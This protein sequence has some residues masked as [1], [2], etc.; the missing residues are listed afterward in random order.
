MNGVAGGMLASQGRSRR[1][2]GGN[3][4]ESAV[5]YPTSMVAFAVAL[6]MLAV[7]APDLAAQPPEK[8]TRAK[9]MGPLECRVV[10]PG[11]FEREGVVRSPATVQ[12][13]GRPDCGGTCQIR[14]A[15]V[16]GD[17]VFDVAEEVFLP[18]QV[19]VIGTGIV[20]RNHDDL[21]RYLR[22]LANWA[23]GVWTESG[24]DAELRF[25]G[26]ARHPKLTGV[27]LTRGASTR[28]GYVP[29]Q[30]V[31]ERFDAHLVY[32]I[33]PHHN[34]NA[35][36]GSGVLGV[37]SP[38]D[39]WRPSDPYV[40]HVGTSND[41]VLS[42]DGLRHGL[43]HEI[44]HN[45]GIHHDP[46]TRARGGEGRPVW[47]GGQGFAGGGENNK[48][49]CG[50]GQ[51]YSR[52]E[53]C[54]GIATHMAYASLDNPSPIWRFSTS[55]SVLVVGEDDSACIDPGVQCFLEYGATYP[56]GEKGVHE[57][58]EVL[59]WNIPRLAM[60][61]ELADDPDPEPD[62]PP[63]DPNPETDL[64]LHGGRFTASMLVDPGDSRLRPARPVDVD[65]P[66][67]S[68]GLFYF[69]SADNAE[70]LFKVLDGCGVNG[71]WWVY[72][73]AAT[74]LYFELTVVDRQRST[75]KRYVSV[76][77]PPPITD[78]TAFPCASGSAG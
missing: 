34:T 14:I 54:G 46:D 27:R 62:P 58:V 50:D 15:F 67:E 41:G 7:N 59:R 70:V 77:L 5:V 49:T 24:L 43:L 63:D 17:D 3:G 55:S 56:L 57:A 75:S 53:G 76:G 51:T 2:A 38:A 74:D 25:V 47:R 18:G 31:R 48:R 66:G 33:L 45:L 29:V 1:S 10:H 6:A 30:K 28:L 60:S 71:H 36:V 9:G 65:L 52:G 37:V 12:G 4:E 16:Y 39:R 40:V 11:D 68:S 32:A 13:E 72:A 42:L 44:G 64:I 23:T 69:F 19:R 73:A 20:L 35:T 78:V 21:R 26:M 61:R 22:A 8:S